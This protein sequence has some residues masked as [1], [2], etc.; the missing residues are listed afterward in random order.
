MVFVVFML[1]AFIFIKTSYHSYVKGVTHLIVAAVVGIALSVLLG[2]YW[3]SIP[4]ETLLS[5]DYF[6]TDA[7]VAFLT[8][9]AVSLFMGSKG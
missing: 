7:L 1:A 2:H 4:L 5:L 3:A 6:R 9:T 8:G